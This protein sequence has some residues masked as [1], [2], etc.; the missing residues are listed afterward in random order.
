MSYRVL[1][2]HILRL[3]N[4]YF[5]MRLTERIDQNTIK[6]I[7]LRKNTWKIPEN[8]VPLQSDF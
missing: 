7:D 2:Q 8:T 5:F 3:Q 1:R 6:I 4:N